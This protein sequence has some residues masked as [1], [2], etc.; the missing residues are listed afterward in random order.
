MAAWTSQCLSCRLILSELHITA[1]DSSA[2]FE[3][4]QVMFSAVWFLCIAWGRTSSAACLQKGGEYKI[5]S[6]GPEEKWTAL[7]RK[8]I[9]KVRSGGEVE[10]ERKRQRK[11]MRVDMGTGARS[12]LYQTHLCFCD[13][14]R[15]GYIFQNSPSEVSP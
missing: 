3:H 5:P 4:N 9:E 11:V 15:D 6:V 8:R 13:C 2:E 10:W 14:F 12:E 7:G 1:S